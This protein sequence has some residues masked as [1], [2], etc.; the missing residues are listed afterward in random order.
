MAGFHE[1]IIVNNET[2]DF[3]F[4]E[5]RNPASSKYFVI[6]HRGSKQVICFEMKKGLSS[7][8]IVPPAP[9]WVHELEEVL[10]YVIADKLKS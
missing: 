5:V 10:G 1:S 6:V 7:W 9:V 3:E 2:F 4:T 8:N